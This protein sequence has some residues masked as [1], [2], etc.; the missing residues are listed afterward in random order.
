MV[1][2]ESENERSG[3]GKLNYCTSF[4]KGLGSVDCWSQYAEESLCQ[5]FT[6]RRR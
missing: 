3:G 4:L 5:D 2:E 1:V 6:P